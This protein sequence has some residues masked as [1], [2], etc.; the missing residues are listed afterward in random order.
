MVELAD[1]LLRS[2]RK[3]YRSLLRLIGKVYRYVPCGQLGNDIQDTEINLL[4]LKFV[5]KDAFG[6]LHVECW[7]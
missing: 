2:E 7:S 5:N 1:T 4:F 3:H 6:M